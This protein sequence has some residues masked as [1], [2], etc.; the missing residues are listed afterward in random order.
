MDSD[1]LAKELAYRA[2][3]GMHPLPVKVFCERFAALGYRIDRSDDCRSNA[4]YMTGERAG[5]SY[6]C[7]TTGIVEADTGLRAFN[8]DA[9]RDERFAAM[10]A[11]RGEVFAVLPSGHILEV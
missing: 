8:R 11:L 3:K 1:R 2:A 9:R 4:R 10:Q 7:C 6:P 5:E